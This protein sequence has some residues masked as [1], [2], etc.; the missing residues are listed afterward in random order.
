[1]NLHNVVAFPPA[2][3]RPNWNEAVDRLEATMR[4]IEA[5]FDDF[6]REANAATSLEQMKRLARMLRRIEVRAQD[7]YGPL[8]YRVVDL[9]KQRALEGA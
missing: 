7:I 2:S 8:M 1:M 9:E 4:D 5:D 6:E 3:I